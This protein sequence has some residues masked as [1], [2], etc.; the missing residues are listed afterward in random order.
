MRFA[1]ISDIHGNI[2]A[3]EA[4]LADI[5]A[6]GIADVVNLG[7]HLS[8]PLEARRTAELLM[9]RGLPSIA[10]NHDRQLIDRPPEAMGATDRHAHGQLERGHVDWL[11][12][13]PPTLTY[14]DDI[15]L[16]HG[17]PRSDTTYWLERVHPD[18]T[19]GMTP[20]ADVAREAIGI[21]ASLILCGHT[22]IP[23]IARLSDG[24]MIVNPGSVGL[25]AYDDDTPVPHLMQSG[26][27]NA[28]YAI[29]DRTGGGWQVTFRF[30]PYDNGSMADLA[31][32]NGR[33]EWAKA[34]ATGWVA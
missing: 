25:P 21:S 28:C 26:T 1:A 23:R 11:K 17:T 13:L 14:R 19:V 4:V 33:P 32:R 34:L 24:R 7:D 20:L 30:V 8:G 29:L 9:A 22:H 16:C 18:G 3:L 27:P 2:L 12:S 6:Q 5:A 10:G 31:Q 15:F